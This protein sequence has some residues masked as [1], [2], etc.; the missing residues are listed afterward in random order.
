VRERRFRLET[1]VGGLHV[2]GAP[3]SCFSLKTADEA[4]ERLRF[5]AAGEEVLPPRQEPGGGSTDDRDAR[6][7]DRGEIRFP[8]VLNRG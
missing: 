1:G 8:E 3:A 7:L 5:V 2:G 4:V 6:R